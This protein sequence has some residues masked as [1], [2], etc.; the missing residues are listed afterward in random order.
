MGNDVRFGPF[1][2][3][4]AQRKLWHAGQRVVLTPREIE[5][6]VLL[7][8][9]RPGIVSKDEIIARLWAGYD[10]SDAALTQ[11][12]YRLRRA[13][14]TH[15]GGDDDY[16]RTVHGIG[17]QFVADDIAVAEGVARFG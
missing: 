1:T 2:L 4:V 10:A 15:D 9:R 6:L 8:D 17:F 14:A 11:A 3:S 16:I 13:L 7:A 5:L 12:I